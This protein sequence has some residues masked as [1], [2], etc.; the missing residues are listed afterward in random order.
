LIDLRWVVLALELWRVRRL[1]VRH[2]V[3][4]SRQGNCDLTTLHFDVKVADGSPSSRYAFPPL[5]TVKYPE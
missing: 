2:S 1:K 5:S 4:R 3:T